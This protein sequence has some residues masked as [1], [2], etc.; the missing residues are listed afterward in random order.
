[1]I[2]VVFY[3]MDW[4]GLPE[5]GGLPFRV[6]AVGCAIWA[7]I[8]SIPIF[9]NVPEP[10]LGRPERKVGF[11]TSYKLLVLDVIALYKTPET[12]PTFWFLLASAV[13]RDGLGG[14]FAFGR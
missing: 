1:M 3:V 13:F 12:R 4:F 10:S 8:F 5:E 2:V 7:I 11:F 6:I 14:V 9:L